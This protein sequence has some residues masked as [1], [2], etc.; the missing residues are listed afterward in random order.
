[1]TDP[2]YA[3][4]Q[5]QNMANRSGNDRLAFV[6]TGISVALLATMAIKEF[7]SLFREVKKDCC[8]WPDQG[9]SR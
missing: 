3:A 7:A 9:R 8:Q 5:M 1:M 4:G 2:I 6:M